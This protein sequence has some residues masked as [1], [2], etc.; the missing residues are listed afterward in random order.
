MESK[1]GPEVACLHVV[2]PLLESL[3]YTSVPENHTFKDPRRSTNHGFWKTV[4]LLT[5]ILRQLI[6]QIK[7][8]LIT[9]HSFNPIV[10]L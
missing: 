6:S 9:L 5:L 10:I 7:P 1:A 8:R 3:S 2:N 4:T